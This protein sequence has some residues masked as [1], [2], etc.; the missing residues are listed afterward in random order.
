MDVDNLN[1]LHRC[2]RSECFTVSVE[3]LVKVCLSGHGEDHEIALAIALLDCDLSAELASL[4]VV[5]ADVKQALTV[6]RIGIDCNDRNTGSD[7]LVDFRRHQLWIGGRNENPRRLGCD[8][9]TE[10]LDFSLG[11]IT[12]RTGELALHLHF[13]RSTADSRRC[14]LPV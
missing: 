9:L 14:S 12:I 7:C 4:I 3:T 1:D 2:V 6:W 11:V 13:M 5:G 10:C 8:G